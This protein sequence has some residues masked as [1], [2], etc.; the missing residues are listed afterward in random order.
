MASTP[1]SDIEK[2]KAQLAD[3]EKQVEKIAGR[4]S[5]N[6]AEQVSDFMDQASRQLKRN[7]DD[8]REQA[9]ETTDKV[10]DYAKK[11]PWQVAGIA[12]AI[13]FLTA[14]LLPRDHKK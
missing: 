6:T 1:T 9:Q 5:D 13:G 14:A 10:H 11:N 12:A 8:T 3:I 7:W 4:L 2:L